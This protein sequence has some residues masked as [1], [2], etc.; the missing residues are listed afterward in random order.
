[1]KKT[2]IITNILSWVNLII[3]GGI[4][5]F[6]LFA[7]FAYPPAAVLLFVILLGSVLLH[8]YA[9]LQLRKSIIY[10]AVPLSRQTPTG[11]RLMGYMA[12]FFGIMAFSNG[13]F[14]LQDTKELIAQMQV[15]DQYKNINFT[16]I[17]RGSAIFFMIFGLGI[18]LNVILN[19]RLLKWYL[20]RLYEQQKKND[21]RES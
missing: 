17:I 6:A 4:M 7:F 8:S 11:I 14:T 12:L 20:M 1:M 18:I 2:L 19:I 9:A 3:G 10:P 13:I 15:P 16:A 21:K 5:L